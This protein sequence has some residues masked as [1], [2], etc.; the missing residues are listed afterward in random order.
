MQSDVAA[1]LDEERA[2][3]DAAVE[4]L[5]G[6]VAGKL[7]EAE[8][9]LQQ[10]LQEQQAAQQAEVAALLEAQ[11]G[12]LRTELQQLLEAQQTELREEVQQR[13]AEADNSAAADR[14]L[15]EG[16]LDKLE[17]QVGAV[18]HVY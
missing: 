11:Q 15:T 3:S 2:A 13:M 17:Q 1:R 4:A 9:G 8:A 10:R 18:G 14:K 12:E 7:A 16:R 5:R 6:E